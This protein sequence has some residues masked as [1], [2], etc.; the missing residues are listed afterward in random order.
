MPMGI[1]HRTINTFVSVPLTG[2]GYLHFHRTPL[3]CTVF[4]GGY[5]FATFLMNPDL[6]LESDGYESWGLLRFYWWPYQKA[7]A[8]RSFFS[9]FP[10]IS[11]VL[12]IV[13]LL[14]LPILLTYFLGSAIQS[15]VR[16]TV[17]DWVPGAFPYLIFLV[18]GMM[19]SDTLHFFLDITSTNLK[20]ALHFGKRRE[21]FF[22]HHGESR[23]SK[24][25][26]YRRGS[27]YGWRNTARRR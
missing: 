21:S 7:F 3:E 20:R 24:G 26:G 10:I 19:C 15:S 6:D 2:A 25:K 5:T 9:H 13:Y 16:E 23:R 1:T 27:G 14:W 4:W 18:A 12:R 8:H 17:F 22:E 11:T